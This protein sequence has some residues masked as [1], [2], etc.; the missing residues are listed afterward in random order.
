VSP[1]PIF[2]A[3]LTLAAVLAPMAV[4]ALVVL[5][6]EPILIALERRRQR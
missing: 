4:I 5:I 6:G 1:D 2:S 3:L